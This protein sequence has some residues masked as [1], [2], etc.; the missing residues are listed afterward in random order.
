MTDTTTT[1]SALDLANYARSRRDGERE[2]LRRRIEVLYLV[3]NP[4]E[5]S[6]VGALKWFNDR[7][8]VTHQTASRWIHRERNPRQQSLRQLEQMEE[9]ARLT[10]GE[11]AFEEAERRRQAFL[12]AVAS[13]QRENG[14]DD[15][16][17]D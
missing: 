7:A 4:D 10:H 2:D 6:L 13:Y 5:D 3:E 15:S 8:G 9:I 12:E 11:D 16:T 17:D 14:T 1:P